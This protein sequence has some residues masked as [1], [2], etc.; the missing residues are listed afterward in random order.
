MHFLTKSGKRKEKK[1][2]EDKKSFPYV[3]FRVKSCFSQLPFLQFRLHVPGA[4]A[5][6]FIFLEK[7]SC[8]WQWKVVFTFTGVKAS[9]FTGSCKKNLLFT[10]LGM[11]YPT[12]GHL[13]CIFTFNGCFPF[14]INCKNIFLLSD[15]CVQ[16]IQK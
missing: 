2:D 13:K 15:A 6:L 5:I 14:N 12:Q 10:S 1:Q 8:F 4:R 3:E 11:A 9:A 7:S 16:E